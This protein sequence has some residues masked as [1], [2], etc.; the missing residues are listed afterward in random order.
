MT[1]RSYSEVQK[2]Q[3]NFIGSQRTLIQSNE[4][5]KKYKKE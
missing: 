3:K 4:V 2:S 1:L 5:Q